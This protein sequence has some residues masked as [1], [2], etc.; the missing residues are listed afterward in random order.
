M[1]INSS[2]KA[3]MILFALFISF[4]GFSKEIAL[5][6]DDAPRAAKGYFDGKT[7]AAK[8]I[9]NLKAHQ[10]EQVAFFVV[11]SRLDAEGVARVNAYNT[12]GH[13]IA[14]HSDTH[15][16]FNRLTLEQYSDNF[17]RADR[18]LRPFSNFSPLYRFPYLREG[19]TLEKR[20]GMRALLKDRG[21][22]NGY[23]TLN[24]YDWYI[25]TLFQQSIKS[26]QPLDM[27]RMRQF[28]VKTLMASI[29]Y[30]DQMANTY[31]GRSPKH[32]LLL[33][34]MDI[35][36]LFIGDLV[37]ELRRQGWKII[38]P[39]QAYTD[40]IALYQTE[41]VLKYNPGRIGEI[42]RDNDQKSNLWHKTL[43][44]A[45]LKQA[46]DQQVLNKTSQE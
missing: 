1:T 10:V 46:F 40:D 41:R 3:L 18:Q 11:T 19:N 45:Y 13:I 12:A 43:D 31:L 27:E 24:N 25:E 26:G 23:I 29:Q 44:E 32:V 38:S 5:T 37:D 42:A 22:R 34:E 30:Y 15:P 8:L 36:A 2:L 35:T 4:D 6:F 9:A 17:L 39:E 20:N 16:D 14:N 21:Y 28:Y 33:H 7:R